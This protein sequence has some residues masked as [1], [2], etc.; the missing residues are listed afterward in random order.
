MDIYILRSSVDSKLCFEEKVFTFPFFKDSTIYISMQTL[1]S[2][3]FRQN[4][5]QSLNYWQNRPFTLQW[6]S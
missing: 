4:T 6:H 2:H 5:C 3:H 1:D